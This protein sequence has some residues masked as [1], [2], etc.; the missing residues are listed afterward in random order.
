MYWACPRSSFDPPFSQLE[1]HSCSP[2]SNR[3]ALRHA[4]GVGSWGAILLRPVNNGKKH[5]AQMGKWPYYRTPFSCKVLLLT[6]GTSV[7]E[8]YLSKERKRLKNA[9]GT[10]IS[11]ILSLTTKALI[12]DNLNE[13]FTSRPSPPLDNIEANMSLLNEFYPIP[14]K[15]AI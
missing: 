8:F 3:G 5:T 9:V 11:W 4:A 7:D 12:L 10:D 14:V 15:F 6:R 2:G 13:F 1:T